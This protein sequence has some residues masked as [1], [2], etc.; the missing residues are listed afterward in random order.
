M[1]IS[2]AARANHDQLFGERVSAL[3]RTDPEFIA[4]FD[5]FAF[6][7]ILADAAELD[8][9]VDL[10]TRLLVQLAAVLAAGGLAEFR[11]LATAG[12]AN[13]GVSPIELKEL[14]YHAV[15]YVGLARVFDFLLAVNDI[16][17]AAGVELPLPGQATSTPETRQGRG[18]QVQERI[19]GAGRVAQMHADAPADCKHFQRYLTGNCFGD[20][21][22]RGGLD[23]PTRELLTFA[24][25]TAI[26]G[27]DAQVRGHVTG[28]LNVGNTRARMLAM[29]TVL[30]PFIGYPRTLNA[31]AA[32]NDIT[33][34]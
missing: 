22:A 12:L 31:L 19:V 24:M 32:I 17:T 16:L 15:P 23:L 18:E 4:Y 33:T 10:H 21:V 20:T 7:E 28:N 5:N 26:G 9:G 30:V 29:L 14:V 13:A 2:D 1:T 8:A 11:V 27:A 34:N 6:D 3:A 25:L